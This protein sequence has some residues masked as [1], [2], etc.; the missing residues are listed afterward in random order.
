[1]RRWLAAVGRLVYS[2]TWSIS[3]FFRNPLR[4]C[5]VASCLAT[6]LD[7][8]K[9]GDSL[10]SG[11]RDLHPNPKDTDEELRERIKANMRTPRT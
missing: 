1:M 8:V 10:T 4:A 6:A 11:Q 9:L 5:S 7:S 3:L 2:I